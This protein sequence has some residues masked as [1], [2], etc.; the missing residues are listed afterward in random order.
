MNKNRHLLRRFCAMLMTCALLIQQTS[1][2][3][4]APKNVS[5]G[6]DTGNDTGKESE[7]AE[8][9]GPPV[10]WDMLDYYLSEEELKKICEEN[11]IDFSEPPIDDSYIEEIQKE[12]S[13]IQRELEHKDD[14]VAA[15]IYNK[16]T[17]SKEKEKDPNY[18]R[19]VAEGALSGYLSEYGTQE[20]LMALNSSRYGLE[21]D[22]LND[23]GVQGFLDRYTA[24]PGDSTF[25][26]TSNMTRMEMESASLTEKSKSLFDYLTKNDQATINRYS[27]LGAEYSRCDRIYEEMSQYRAQSDWEQQMINE[28]RLHSKSYKNPS[29]EELGTA[30]KLL[31]N[32][33]KDFKA[34]KA[35]WYRTGRNLLMRGFNIFMGGYTIYQEMENLGTLTGEYENM[36]DDDHAASWLGRAGLSITSLTSGALALLS[37]ISAEI[38]SF[39]IYSLG[40][41]TGGFWGTLAGI[42]VLVAGTVG[43]GW[44]ATTDEFKEHTS[45]WTW[46]NLRETWQGAKDI[47]FGN[48]TDANAFLLDEML[49]E[50]EE[51]PWKQNMDEGFQEMYYFFD[52]LIYRENS[53]RNKIKPAPGIGALK[54]NIY[55]Y[56]ET[57]QNISVTFGMPQ[58]LTKSIPDY[59]GTWQVRATPGGILNAADGS[60]YGYLFYESETRPY[61]F[62]KDEGWLIKS[63]TRASQFEK[64]L[65]AYGF[66]NTEI[67]DFLE[68]WTGKLSEDEDFMMY[69]QLTDTIDNAM[70]VKVSPEPDNIFRLW[71]TFEPYADQEVSK[72][73]IEPISRNGY[74]VVEWGGVILNE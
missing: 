51:Y 74:T 18:K 67:R 28:G 17:T 13:R 33:K 24:S 45:D 22:I 15:R 2:S 9:Y 1:F 46:R 32:S 73:V 57:E 70:P 38:P 52:D 56:T 3:L 50:L 14:I 36:T 21:L 30:K 26:N 59:T 53:E 71:F 62:Q 29:N 66:N 40:T 49:T 61:Y 35:K 27:E 72:P 60:T 4:G 68:F 34:D 20:A 6:K 65:K 25:F 10:P 44:L 55:I 48:I 31:D 37:G 42:A 54:P 63:D 19:Q 5:S 47:A 8:T 64:I 69:P 39:T 58:W 41:A 7:P 23:G 11:D 16:T 12:Y 43:A